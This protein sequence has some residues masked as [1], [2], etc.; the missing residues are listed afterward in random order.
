MTGIRFTGVQNYPIL[1]EHQLTVDNI[2]PYQSGHV[3]KREMPYLLALL[4][5]YFIALMLVMR[6][7]VIRANMGCI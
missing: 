1:Y 7:I 3:Y 4:K 2:A 5:V 6:Y